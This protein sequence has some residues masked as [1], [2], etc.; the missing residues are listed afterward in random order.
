MKHFYRFILFIFVLSFG[1]IGCGS[2]QENTLTSTDTNRVAEDMA[3]GTYY[4][5]V[6]L[7]G[8]S[9]RATIATPTT[10]I[11]KEDSYWANI[12]WSS[13]NYDYMIVDQV[14]Y[15]VAEDLMAAD[16]H[17]VFQIPVL[18][19]DEPF[20][21]IA[22]T[23]AMSTPHEIEYTLTF[24]KSS[25]RRN[26]TD[27]Q[28]SSDSLELKGNEHVN[29]W[30]GASLAAESRTDMRLSYATQFRVTDLDAYSLITIGDATQYL[31]VP[32]GKS[33]PDGVPE[34]VAILKQP[35][36][37]IYLVSSSCMDFYRVLS[38]MEQLKFAGVKSSDWYIEEVKN[39][40]EQGELLYAGKYNAP[41][42][43]SLLAK[44]CDL[45]IENT[46]IYH[47]PEVKEQL[48][49]LGISVLVETS[50][51][52]SN[53][54]GRMEWIKLHGLLLGKRELAEAI[55]DEQVA[56]LK[57]GIRQSDTKKTV[58]LFYISSSGVVHVK[59]T[60]DYMAELI[61]MAG[62]TYLFDESLRSEKLQMEEFYAVA[63]DADYLIY[64]SIIDGE[65][66]NI[67][68]LLSKNQL[69]SDFRAV[70][71][72]NVWCLQKN[73]FQQTMGLGDLILDVNEIINGTEEEYLTY[74]H[75]LER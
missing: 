59:K 75:H 10:L 9:G 48:E 44:N 60:D 15:E 11:K 72:G 5:D 38:G 42:Y 33:V 24:Y 67:Q 1:L 49:Q 63:K 74:L 52:E 7:D 57:T 12:V 66:E 43:E 41:D 25:I 23:T 37:N 20:S 73:M 47:N 26:A 35:L 31:L 40:M 64:N 2:K 19:W 45:A 46:M 27:S 3:D 22:D 62:G 28:N 13:S 17:S 56:K 71:N 54:L 39:A 8:G 29:L 30:D 21:V 53:P 16:G 34:G 32:E 4:V 50:S 61:R 6:K 65:L 58:V 70:Q 14:K 51:Y 55:F 36:N 68:A 18:S 69:L